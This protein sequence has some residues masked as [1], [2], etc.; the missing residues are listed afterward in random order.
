MERNSYKK[1]WPFT[2]TIVKDFTP[3]L[4]ISR[5]CYRHDGRG[6]ACSG[7]K[8]HYSFKISQNANSYIAHVDS[9]QTVVVKEKT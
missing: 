6:L 1:P 8:R 4:F 5:A 7:C 3:P 2:P 9:C